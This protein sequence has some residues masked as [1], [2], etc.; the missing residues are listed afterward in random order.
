MTIILHILLLVDLK[1]QI[2]AFTEPFM[3]LRSSDQFL[4]SHKPNVIFPKHGF[5]ALV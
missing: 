2:K 1:R 4:V 5:T 3:I